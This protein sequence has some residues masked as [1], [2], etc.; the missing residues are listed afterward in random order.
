MIINII[1]NF[2]FNK[3]INTKFFPINRNIRYI[4]T[5]LQ[6]DYDYDYYNNTNNIN[7]INYSSIKYIQICDLC[8]GSGFIIHSNK[9]NKMN[10]NDNNDNNLNFKYETCY[11]CNGYG[12]L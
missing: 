5:S 4:N 1:K 8:N 10:N 7:Y 6:Q 9:L 12:F 2:I 3:K 11:K